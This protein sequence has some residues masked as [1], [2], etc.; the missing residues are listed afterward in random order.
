MGG[1][2]NVMDNDKC[3]I[4]GHAQRNNI[5]QNMEMRTKQSCTT[6]CKFDFLVVQSETESAVLS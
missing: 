4:N 1:E 5:S 6:T 2:K 3:A